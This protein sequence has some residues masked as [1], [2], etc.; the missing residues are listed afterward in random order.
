MQGLHM[1]GDCTCTAIYTFYLFLGHSAH[2]HILGT[3]LHCN[4]KTS[5]SDC[6]YIV[7]Q[8]IPDDIAFQTQSFGN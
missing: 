3:L 4:A 7:G 1:L 8:R 6:K 5:F 2:L